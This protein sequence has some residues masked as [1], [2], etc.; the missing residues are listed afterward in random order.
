M[1]FAIR[2]NITLIKNFSY[3][4]VIQVFNMVLPLVVFPYLIRMLG[5][6]VYGIVVFAQAIISYLVILV[7]FG[8]NLSAT[9]Q[10]S[11]HRDDKNELSEIVSST[12]ILKGLLF[13]L[14][15]LIV[16]ILIFVIP[17]IKE[18]KLLYFLSLSMCLYEFIFP[19]WYFQGIERMKYITILNLVNRGIFVVLTFILVKSPDDYLLVPGLNG[20]G[21]I[22]TGFITVYLIF[23][24]DRIRF[25][26]P[27]LNR[28][29]FHIRES[30]PYFISNISG[31]LYVKA[32]KVIVGMFLG[33]TEVAYYDLA[34]KV[35]TVLKIPQQIFNQAL[36]PKI[37]KEN[38]KNLVKRLFK[39]SVGFNVMIAVL[40]IIFARYIV[41]LLG[42]DTMLSSVPI[43]QIIVITVPIIGINSIYVMQLLL[44]FGY[45][46][47]YMQLSLESLGVFALCITVLFLTHRMGIYEIAV[48]NI[49]TES[50]MNFRAFKLCRKFH[51][52]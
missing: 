21:A 47:N 41:I 44:P 37:S 48:V 31:Q 7:S 50:Y 34:E 10:V 16:A 22:L 11:I 36:F 35:V 28:L 33:M 14:S 9:K 52:F 49:I 8:F 4:S 40:V 25:I 42:S 17:Q 46:R 18:Y 51:L 27:P 12:F 6:E 26:L 45:Q 43:L 30:Y 20:I 2:N 13:L 23:G 5:R 29:L 1:K 15:L 19:I 3:L 24:K 39:Y 38:N 32:N